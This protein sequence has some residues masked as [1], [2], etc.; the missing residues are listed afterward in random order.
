M[1]HNMS[2]ADRIIRLIVAAI[3]V[4][5]YLNHNIEGTMGMIFIVI[6]VVFALTSFISFCPLYSLFGLS[7]K[8][9]R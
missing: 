3:I 1:N 8:K 2:T 4:F 5:L 6:A 7:S 9:K